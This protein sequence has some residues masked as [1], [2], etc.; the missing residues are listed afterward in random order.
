MTQPGRTF[1]AVFR[2]DAS[3]DIGTGHVMRCL[4][5][6]DALH[7]RG[8]HCVFICRDLPGHL[9][10]RIRLHGFDVHLLANTETAS[11]NE[12]S[13]PVHASWLGTSWQEDAVQAA[14]IL[15]ELKPDWLVVDHYALDARWEKQ[16][17]PQCGNILVIDD[18]AD[19]Q[20]DCDV[21]LDQNLGRESSDYAA[22]VPASCPLLIGSRFALLRPEFAD[23]RPRALNRRKQARLHRILVTM[24]GIDKDNATGKVL[25]ALKQCELPGNA[26]IVVISGSVAPH[27]DDVREQV[28]KMP[29][30]TMLRTNIDNMAEEMILADVAIGAA[31][32][33]SWERCCLGL[34]TIMLVL[35][36]N[37]AGIA[38]ALTAQGAAIPVTDV[39]ASDFIE[40]F[41]MLFNQLA[42][43]PQRLAALSQAAAG[44]ADGKGVDRVIEQLMTVKEK[45]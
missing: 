4:T 25:D 37:Q 17:R 31:G 22:H 12:E 33:T 36:K 16:L 10:E 15:G 21:L 34:P 43:E 28:Q 2:V 8:A 44:V 40:Q 39:Q 26:E 5:L 23:A 35:A 30:R 38:R 18:L 1:R 42:H 20:H 14:A 9:A 24:G 41:T 3:V 19:R 11:G 27:L 32:S 13:L 6:A 7:G 29:V 45:A